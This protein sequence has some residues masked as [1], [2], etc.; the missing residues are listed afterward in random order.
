MG[1]LN[2][3]GEKMLLGRQVHIHR[4]HECPRAVLIVSLPIESLA[5]RNGK[6]SKAPLGNSCCLVTSDTHLKFGFYAP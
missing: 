5:E 4:L 1:I 6:L 2:S 3:T